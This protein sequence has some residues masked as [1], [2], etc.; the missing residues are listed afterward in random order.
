MP[1][2]YHENKRDLTSGGGSIDVRIRAAQRKDHE[3]IWKATVETVWDDLP[4]YEKH[5]LDRGAFEGHFRPHAQRVIESPDTAIFVAEGGAGE[6]VGY[7]VLG[8]ATSMLSPVP[9]GF[10][11]DVW[12]A[13]AFRRRGVARRLLLRAE[14]WCR[15]QGHGS[16][17]LEVSARN[18][19]ARAL[20]ASA[21]F[22]EDRLTLHKAL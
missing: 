9:F 5:G 17:R 21:G 12:V 18:T 4:L 8:P 19:A 6:P 14:E 11:Y 10:V 20:Y 1:R 22:V 13:P 7:V 2:G 16:I 3:V 15:A